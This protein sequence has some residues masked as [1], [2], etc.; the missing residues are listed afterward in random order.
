MKS[1]ISFNLFSKGFLCNN[2]IV[3][4]NCLYKTFKNKSLFWYHR[5][6]YVLKRIIHMTDVF[7]T[8]PMCSIIFLFVYWWNVHIR[9]SVFQKTWPKRWMWQTSA[10][11]SECGH[12]D[13]LRKEGDACT[14]CLTCSFCSSRI[15][16]V[17]C[18]VAHSVWLISEPLQR[19]KAQRRQTRMMRSWSSEKNVGSGHSY[20]KGSGTYLNARRPEGGLYCR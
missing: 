19:N 2:W 17:I 9:T 8:F 4:H 20:H 6:N 18:N 10:F 5:I 14:N 11:L 1:F 13:L 15:F 3:F 16:A 7:F 12:L